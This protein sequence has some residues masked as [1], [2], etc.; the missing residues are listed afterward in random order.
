MGLPGALE[1][2][3]RAS[4]LKSE[5]GGAEW[6]PLGRVSINEVW[7]SSDKKSFAIYDTMRHKLMIMTR[8]AYEREKKAHEAQAGRPKA[9]Q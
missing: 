6:K 9:T 4:L 1:Y 3:K 5:G 7:N 2:G 8:A